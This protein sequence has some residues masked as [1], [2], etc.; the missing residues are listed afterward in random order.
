MSIQEAVTLNF[1]A[2]WGFLPSSPSWY[3]LTQAAEAMMKPISP[4]D[5]GHNTRVLKK[6]F[7]LRLGFEMRFPGSGEVASNSETAA[8]TT[9]RP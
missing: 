3:K 9:L 6:V 5:S 7:L 8:L 2:F 1:G 4:T